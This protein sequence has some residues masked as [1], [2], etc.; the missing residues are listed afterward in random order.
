[1]VPKNRELSKLINDV[2]EWEKKVE[3][4]GTPE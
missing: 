3:A 1:M 4:T 2:V